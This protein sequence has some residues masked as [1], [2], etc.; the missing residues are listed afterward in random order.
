MLFVLL[1]CTRC[2]ASDLSQ[3]K[4]QQ[5][6]EVQNETCG[7]TGGGARGTANVWQSNEDF[8]FK[9]TEQCSDG[10]CYVFDPKPFIVEAGWT[11]IYMIS[12]V[13]LLGMSILFSI[14]VGAI[15][16]TTKKCRTTI[17]QRKCARQF[18]INIVGIG[19][20][21]SVALS[22][23]RFGTYDLTSDQLLW[24]GVLRPYGWILFGL[25]TLSLVAVVLHHETNIPTKLPTCSGAEQ[26]K[27]QDEYDCNDDS[28]CNG[29]ADRCDV[30]EEAPMI[31]K[32]KLLTVL[33]INKR[34]KKYV[35]ERPVTLERI[36]RWIINPAINHQ[37]QWYQDV[38]MEKSAVDTGAFVS[39]AWVSLVLIM[40]IPVING[41]DGFS[42]IAYR[43]IDNN[44]QN[45]QVNQARY[46]ATLNFSNL[47]LNIAIG[48][49]TPAPISILTKVLTT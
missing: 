31:I 44:N 8:L 28:T 14:I 4:R 32:R 38:K 41:Y 22:L 23:L 2:S 24:Q 42:G 29:K 13:I 49:I 36:K 43:D 16:S 11:N 37:D 46:T 20:T 3:E 5:C 6:L 34:N 27:G 30:S 25:N 9:C 15:L 21:Y 1:A 48:L 19:V 47:L 45:Y 33:T 17:D 10:C 26:P 40:M 18:A 7:T 35:L 39:G 12:A